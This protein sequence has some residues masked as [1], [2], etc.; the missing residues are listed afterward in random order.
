MLCTR[1]VI[2]FDPATGEITGESEF[3]IDGYLFEK[4]TG[5]MDVETYSMGKYIGLEDGGSVVDRKEIRLTNHMI[6]QKEDWDYSYTVHIQKSDPT[7][8]YIVISQ[9][10]GESIYA[11]CGASEEEALVN[12]QTYREKLSE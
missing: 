6:Q 3:R 12:L 10:D 7:I 11:I 9:R 4:F 2:F 1:I 8:I 5:V